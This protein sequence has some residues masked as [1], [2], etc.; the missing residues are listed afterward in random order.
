MTLFY[1][2][3]TGP[4]KAKQRTGLKN[5][6]FGL[7][8]QRFLLDRASMHLL[9]ALEPREQLPIRAPPSAEDSAIGAVSSRMSALFEASFEGLL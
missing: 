9:T 7:I 3:P 6:R 2:R 8:G 4:K 1:L 5:S